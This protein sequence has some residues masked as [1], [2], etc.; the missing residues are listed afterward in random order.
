MQYFRNIRFNI[1]YLFEEILLKIKHPKRNG[2]LWYYCYKLWDDLL[3]PYYYTV[4]GVKNLFVWFKTI[5]FIR[6]FDQWY[7]LKIMDKQLSEMEK[8][9]HSGNSHV[10]GDKHI[11]KRITWTRKLLKMHFDEYYISKLYNECHDNKPNFFESKVVSCDEFGVP[12]CYQMIDTRTEEQKYKFRTGMDKAHKMDE[13]VWKLFIKN[14][15]R[16]REWWD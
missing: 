12:S 11:A 8:F 14:F 2:E 3:D 6:T 13:K 5:W 7:L 9:W 4:R 16:C 15:S 10:V 1:K